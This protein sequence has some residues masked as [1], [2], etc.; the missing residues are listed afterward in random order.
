MSG[1]R[2]TGSLHLGNYFGALE[3]WVKLQNEYE[4]FFSIVDWH[5]LTTGYEDT[6]EIKN[7]IMEIAIDWL[8]A[9]LDPEKCT[10][11]IQSNVKEIAELHLL[12][13]M[14]VPLSWLERCPT[15]KEQL[16]QLTEK[17]I[18]T[19][20]FLGYPNLMATDILIHKASFVPVGEDQQPHLELAREI[21]RRFN[22]LYGDT[23][24]VPQGKMTKI[25]VLPGLDGRKMSKSYDNTI[26][27]SDSP[28]TIR[29]KVRQMVT[30][31][32]KI[33]KDDPGHPD[34]C[35]VYAFHKVFSEKTHQ[36]TCEI[37]EKGGIGCVQCKKVLAEN[38]VDY[39]APMYERRQKLLKDKEG[40]IEIL[41][42]GTR[43]AREVARITLAEVRE[44]MK[45]MELE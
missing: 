28:D 44:K 26:A 24:P 12:L 10:I 1:M 18:T 37:C 25:K 31:K 29:A 3:N 7:N 33:K 39:M 27:L 45:L 9:G 13:S 41:R 15:Y 14:T 4:C 2:P 35:A 21:S 36:D 38:I 23:F 20:G 22:N 34:I 40:I 17:N 8:S 30:D 5:A 43:H 11:F 19:Y 16:S 6:S 42:N 32:E